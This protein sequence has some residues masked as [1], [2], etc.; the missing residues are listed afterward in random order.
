MWGITTVSLEVAPRSG[1]CTWFLR[2]A[3][4]YSYALLAIE[5][6]NQISTGDIP[7]VDIGY[8]SKSTDLVQRFAPFTKTTIF[9]LSEPSRS[10]DRE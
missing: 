4:Q 8:P 9:S 1:L 6:E 7:E 5:R 2:P 10:A 3:E